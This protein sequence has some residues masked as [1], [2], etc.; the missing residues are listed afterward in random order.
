MEHAVTSAFAAAE[1]HENASQCATAINTLLVM[2]LAAAIITP[3]Q[4]AEARAY[5]LATQVIDIVIEALAVNPSPIPADVRAPKSERV[6]C[7]HCG[8]SS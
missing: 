3:V 5:I 6:V 1:Q 7:G 2:M 4:G 8:M